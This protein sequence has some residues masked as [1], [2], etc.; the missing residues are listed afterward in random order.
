MRNN[1][2][3]DF[4]RRKMADYHIAPKVMAHIVHIG[5]VISLLEDKVG[6]TEAAAS[7]GLHAQFSE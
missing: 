4:L 6:A 2:D 7:S 3:C 1:P 5:N